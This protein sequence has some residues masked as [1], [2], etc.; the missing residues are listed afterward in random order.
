KPSDILDLFEDWIEW[1]KSRGFTMDGE[2]IK[3]SPRT[4][5]GTPIMTLELFKGIETEPPRVCRRL[6]LVRKWSYDKQD[7]EQIFT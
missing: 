1:I 2:A 5:I 6:Q 7:N 4:G 3:V